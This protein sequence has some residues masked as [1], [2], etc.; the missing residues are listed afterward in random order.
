MVRHESEQ[1]PYPVYGEGARRVL[2]QV[3]AG[4]RDGYTGYLREFTLEPAANTPYH[5]HDW[6]HLVYILEGSGRLKIDGQEHALK[7]GSV[8]HVEAGRTHG[9]FNQ[10]GERLRFL[11][12]VPE[13][14]DS[15]SEAD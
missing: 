5:H 1:R 15:Y 2:K 10:E 12:L 7:A 13:N 9:F 4:P 14:G 8:V 11:C 6:D 3:L